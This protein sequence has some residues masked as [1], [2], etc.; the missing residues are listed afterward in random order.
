MKSKLKL[1]QLD[2]PP[3]PKLKIS[4]RVAF[5]CSFLQLS[6]SAQSDF[7]EVKEL[8]KEQNRNP[9]AEAETK[10]ETAGQIKNSLPFKYTGNKYSHKFHRP[11]CPFC[12]A[13]APSKRLAFHF[14]CQAIAAGYAPCKYCLPARW[15]TVQA[16][17][18]INSLNPEDRPDPN[19]PLGESR[20]ETDICRP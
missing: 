13:M 1:P 6:A 9:A 19:L 4:L 17:I 18:H 11:R 14:R 10:A 16:A 12:R 20:R 5:L 7:A 15:T 8:S 2:L 3:R